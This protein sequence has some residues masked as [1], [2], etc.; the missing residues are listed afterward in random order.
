VA[1]TT[2]SERRPLLARDIDPSYRATTITSSITD[3]GAGGDG[4]EGPSFR[5]LG[6]IEYVLPDGA[7]FSQAI[8]APTVSDEDWRRQESER[9]RDIRQGL[10]FDKASPSST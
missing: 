7:A 1:D 4:G 3:A 10:E 5:E 9:R 6:W 2:P 8:D